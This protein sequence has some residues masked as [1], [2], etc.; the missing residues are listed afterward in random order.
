MCQTFFESLI[1][2]LHNLN[3]RLWEL[4]KIYLK[5][6]NANLLSIDKR[7][8]K[9][10][11]VI[12]TFT[13]LSPG[14]CKVGWAHWKNAS[15]NRVEHNVF[16]YFHYMIVHIDFS[17]FSL[18]VVFWN[19]VVYIEIKGAKQPLDYIMNSL[20]WRSRGHGCSCMSLMSLII[21]W[22]K[23]FWYC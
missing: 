11:L 19:S 15:A 7:S 18:V 12:L 9:E 1:N 4:P 2:H 6:L 23:Y 21:F 3:S 17:L 5:N 13:Q 8:F 10:T 22:M 20:S 14:P 16:F